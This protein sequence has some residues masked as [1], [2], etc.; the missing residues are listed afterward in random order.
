VVVAGLMGQFPMGGM[1]WQVLHHVL[2][3]RRLG[4][5][6]Y[7]IENSGAPPYSPRRGSVGEDAREN[8]AFLARTFPRFG[9]ADAWAYYDCLED[10][11]HGGAGARAGEL[12]EHADVLVNLCGASRPESFARRK[13]CLVYLE[14][15]PVLEQLNLERGD[16]RTREFIAGHD[17]C[18]TYAWNL[19]QPRCPLPTGGVAWRRTRPPVLVDL[20]ESPP[21]PRGSWRTIAT[22]RNR[23]KDVVIDGETYYWSKHLNYERMVDLPARTRERLEIALASPGD[24]DAPAR[25]RAHGWRIRD[26]YPVSHSTGVY[27]SYLRGAKGEF[28]VE[29]DSVVRLHTGWFSDRSVCLLAAG[30]P[31]VLQDTGLGPDLPTGEGLL[32]WSSLEE[33]AEALERVARDYAQHARRARELAL[34]FFEARVLLPEILDAA[35]VGRG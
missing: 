31:C 5:E 2:G 6:C 10:R 22:Y 19:G 35:G 12:L 16:E 11:W 34:E 13:G 9:L 21:H 29:K 27:R 26:A 20:W 25:L 30:R 14:T 1:A 28:S 18:F 23:G 4:C 3:F 15:D 8:V 7:Y 17:V 24:P 33:A 32:A